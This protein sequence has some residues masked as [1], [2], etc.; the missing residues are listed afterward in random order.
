MS[1]PFKDWGEDWPAEWRDVG[2]RVEL[3]LEDGSTVTGTL[4]AEEFFT[5]EDEI[6]I[7]TVRTDDGRGISFVD[8]EKWRYVDADT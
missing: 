8:H 1:E 5:G 4:E 2:R 3:L 7:F 6:P